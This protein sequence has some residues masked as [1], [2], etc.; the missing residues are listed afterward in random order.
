MAIK[1]ENKDVGIINKEKQPVKK[2]TLTS[3][4]DKREKN[5]D[6]DAEAGVDPHVD[7]LNDMPAPDTH[8]R[9]PKSENSKGGANS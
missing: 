3:V 7:Q 6:G 1:I 5:Q 4:V 8:P 2:K 9:E